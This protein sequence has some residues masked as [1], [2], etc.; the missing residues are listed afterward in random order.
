MEISE[1][2]IN[3]KAPFL[4]TPDVDLWYDGDIYD[5]LPEKNFY[6]QIVEECYVPEIFIDADIEPLIFVNGY[7]F[8]DFDEIRTLIS[9]LPEDSGI[10]SEEMY[11]FYLHAGFVTNNP[12]NKEDVVM[13]NKQ[14]LIEVM[15]GFSQSLELMSLEN[16]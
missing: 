6:K 15:E 3:G 4:S 1:K 14:E 2:C 7:K 11:N 12:P 8:Y 9:T 13:W 10:E 5:L 16:N